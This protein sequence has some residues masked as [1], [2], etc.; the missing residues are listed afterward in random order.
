MIDLARFVR[1]LPMK[2]LLILVVGW[3]AV[4]T[5]GCAI[6][7]L[8]V[9]P[10][11]SS[12]PRQWV[13]QHAVCPLQSSTRLQNPQI[14]GTHRWAGGFIVL[15]SGLCPDNQN[16]TGFRQVFGH[17]IVKQDGINWIV[18][19][20]DSFQVE[21]QPK[22]A[23]RLVDYRI[24]RSVYQ[25]RDR[26]TIVYGQVLKPTVATIEA[27][28]DNGTILRDFGQDG[29]FALLAPG[30]TGVCEVRMLGSDNQILQ[31]VDLAP[32]QNLMQNSPPHQCLPVSHQL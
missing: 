8:A 14:L 11:I 20:S 31:Q 12:L 7:L 19:G 23:K 25:G 27:T 17:Q 5:T 22:K 24:S 2:R 10:R 21:N 26:F 4:S 13:S 3:V 18:S 9:M 1:S 16:A 30:A 29:V 28:F 15:Y 6:S 32:P